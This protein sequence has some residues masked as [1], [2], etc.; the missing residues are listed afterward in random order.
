MNEIEEIIREF[1]AAIFRSDIKPTNYWLRKKLT[2][3]VSKAEAR[4]RKEGAAE[5]RQFI[6][7]VLDYPHYQLR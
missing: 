4:G 1:G 6:L 2:E 7:N 5:E 3:L